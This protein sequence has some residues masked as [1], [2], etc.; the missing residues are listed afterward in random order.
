[1]TIEER[2]RELLGKIDFKL[3]SHSWDQIFAVR[4]KKA[5]PMTTW[6]ITNW[7]DWCAFGELQF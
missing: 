6:D 3:A 2:E 5:G 4:S 1:M 7:N